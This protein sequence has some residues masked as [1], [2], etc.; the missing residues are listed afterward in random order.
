MKNKKYDKYRK[1]QRT[2]IAGASS[3]IVAGM[4]LM[5]TASTALAEATDLSVPAYTEN[6]AKGMHLMH[7]WNSTKKA[8]S[9]GVHLGLD[10]AKV[11]QELKSGKTLK[12]ILQENGIVPDQLQKAF[13]NS[14][15]KRHNSD[16]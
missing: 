7:R 9:L 4:L 13:E 15:K 14:G 2:I 11:K 3:G 6:T 12:Q 10:R 16:S 5:G 8:S 1:I